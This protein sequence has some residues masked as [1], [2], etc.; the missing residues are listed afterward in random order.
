MEN[1]NL[2]TVEPLDDQ[3]YFLWSEKVE[4]I[5]RAKKL[6]KKVINVKPVEKPVE[7]VEN[8]EAKYKIW[9]QWDDDNYAARAVMINTMSSSQLLKYT[10]EKSADKLWSL[11]KYNMAA[12]TEQLKTKF[13][14]DLS[15]LRMNKDESVDAYIN[16]AEALRNQCIQLGKNIEEYE[17]KMYIL[18]GLR[19][20]FDQNVRV[21]DSQRELTINDIRYA[22]KQEESRKTKRLEERT[23]KN[24]YVRRA[25]DNSKF[26]V[27]CYNCGM[28][29]H[30]S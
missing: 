11:I 7:G 23:S 1:W 18:N 26:D 20:E 27:T 16:R 25:K 4:G 28:K 15:N 12:G 17:V 24:E 8:Y 5:L 30:V 9:N 13:L 14:S 10:R 19:S 22:L 3:N 6:W 2:T 21:M 29:G